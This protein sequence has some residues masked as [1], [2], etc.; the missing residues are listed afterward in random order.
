MGSDAMQWMLDNWVW[1]LLGVGM[2]AMH[3]FGHGGHGR[4]RDDTARAEPDTKAGLPPAESR[5]RGVGGKN[6]TAGGAEKHHDT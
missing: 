2:V 6:G 1:I 3:M 4:R 5:L